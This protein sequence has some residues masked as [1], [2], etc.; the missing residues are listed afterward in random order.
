MVSLEEGLRIFEK[1]YP[2]RCFSGAE[3][4]EKCFMYGSF[5][6]TWDGNPD[7]LKIGR[8]MDVIDKETGEISRHGMS[9]DDS[10]YG[11]F[12]KLI[13]LLPY[14]SESDAKYIRKVRSIEESYY[15]KSTS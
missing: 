8:G 14:L 7:H 5:E 3:E 2:E 9:D 13:D 12:I 15:S 10:I 11:R 6:R 4:Y 1:M